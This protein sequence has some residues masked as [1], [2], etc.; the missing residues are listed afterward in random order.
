MYKLVPFALAASARNSWNLFVMLES[1]R[2]VL[3]GF[4]SGGSDALLSRWNVVLVLAL[5]LVFLQFFTHALVFA[6][7]LAGH[8]RCGHS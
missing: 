8:P 3:T 4:I 1:L 5:A 6:L 7:V 2:F